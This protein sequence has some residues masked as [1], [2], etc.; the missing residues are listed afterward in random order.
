MHFL[1]LLFTKLT[2]NI[3]SL[4]SIH[5]LLIGKWNLHI[6][7]F[8]INSSIYRKFSNLSIL[9]CEKR[10]WHHIFTWQNLR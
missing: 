2:E 7:N 6:S 1:S 5:P 4:R 8:S 10:R 9:C 3:L